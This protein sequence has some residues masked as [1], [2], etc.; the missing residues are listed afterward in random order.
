MVDR[1]AWE[2]PGAFEELPGVFRI[3]LPL[4]G[5]ALKAVNVY[6]IVDD[7]KVVLVDSGWA[8][9]ESQDLL[10]RSLDS[11]GFGLGD[12]REFLVTHV[13]RDH[14][15]QAVAIRRTYG[16]SVSLGE[17]E[18]I[19]LEAI[20]TIS[21]HPDIA[22]LHAAGAL[23]LSQVIAGWQGD[24]DLTDWAAPDRWLD[25]GLELPLHSR[26]LRVIA[27]PGHTQGHVVF[28]DP[29]HQALFAGDHVL[30]HIT[31][32]IGVELERAPS[33]LRDYLSSL[34][35]IRALPDTRLLPAHGPVTASTAD[36]ID[37]LLRHHE[38]RL[39]ETGKAVEAGAT[40]GF[41]VANILTWTR[42]GRHFDELDTFNQIL[43]THETMAHLEVLV[44]RGWLRRDTVDGIVR[45][46]RA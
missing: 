9:A 45:F 4:P 38:E 5:D 13:H 19:S 31:P 1:H 36:R 12:I 15:T 37:E 6:A 32:S 7:D 10:G 44:E 17:G 46:A 27:T 16:T 34:Q 14:Y 23:G 35:L 21:A 28:H 40:S 2:E 11:I 18:R 42:R 39:T 33:P 43:A 29:Q 24:R 3:P 30:P 22:N 41:E 8:M 25:D 26:T 20:H